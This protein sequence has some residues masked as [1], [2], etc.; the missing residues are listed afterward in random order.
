MSI[1]NSIYEYTS[2]TLCRIYTLILN[3]T[4]LQ[5]EHQFRNHKHDSNDPDP[6]QVPIAL[7]MTQLLL[8]LPEATLNAH[9]PG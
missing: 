2:T 4:F 1:M 9:L 5:P 3:V 7:A 6:L 8:Q